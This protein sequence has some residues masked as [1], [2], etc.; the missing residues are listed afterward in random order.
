MHCCTRKNSFI[1]DDR[2]GEDGFTRAAL[3]ERRTHAAHSHAAAAVLAALAGIVVVGLAS[4]IFGR[5]S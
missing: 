5:R 3:E 1:S 4:M 2:F